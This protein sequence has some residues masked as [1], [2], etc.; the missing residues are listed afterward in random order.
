MRRRE[1]IVALSAAAWSPAA[2]QA[3]RRIGVLLEYGEDDPEGHG[4]T[5]GLVMG[6]VSLRGVRSGS[7]AG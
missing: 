1:F 7:A 2:G 3:R 5:L 4:H 6:A